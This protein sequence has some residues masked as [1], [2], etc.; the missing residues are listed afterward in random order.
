MPRVLRHDD[1][2]SPFAGGR[3]RRAPLRHAGAELPICSGV[4]RTPRHTRA[5][6]FAGR[7]DARRIND[8]R[9][10]RRLPVHRPESGRRPECATSRRAGPG[11]ATPSTIGPVEPHAF[12]DLDAS[13][14]CFGGAPE[15]A[16]SRGFARS[17]KSVTGRLV[18][19]PGRGTGRVRLLR[20]GGKSRTFRISGP[21]CSFGEIARG[22]GGAGAPAAE[23]SARRQRADPASAAGLR[24]GRRAR[25]P[26][27]GAAAG[28]RGRPARGRS[29]CCCASAHS[30]RRSSPR[31]SACRRERS[32]T[33]S[34][35]SR[36]QG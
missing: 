6:S 20:T 2:L 23:A 33:T 35:C 31:S 32:A 26:R 19:G 34:R 22:G 15:I 27:A 25:R 3:S 9:T 14:S 7:Y 10:S 21:F 1:A 18:P 17:S 11:A 28:A 13:S 12:V 16:R 8:E 29:S 5:T 24:R 36:R 30:R 4:Q